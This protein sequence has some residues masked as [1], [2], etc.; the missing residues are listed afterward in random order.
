MSV[1]KIAINDYDYALPE[2]RIAKYPLPKRDESKLLIYKN[3]GI[4][5][6]IFRNLPE[7]IPPESQLYVNDT[8]V[9]HA[10]LKFK[11]LTGAKIELFCLTPFEPVDY[12]ISFSQTKTCTWICMVGNLKKWKNEILQLDFVSN[13]VKYSLKA[14]KVDLAGGHAIVRFKWDGDLSFGEVLDSL[15]K[16]PIPPYL[17][18]E[19][20]TIDDSRYQT[21][22]SDIKGSVAAPTAGLHITQDVISKLKKKNIVPQTIT[23]HVGAGT[24][25]PVK[26]DN[27]LKHAMHSEVFSVS[28]QTLT[29]LAE[30]NTPVIATGTTTLRTLESLY[31]LGVKSIEAQKLC[32]KLEQWDHK[33]LPDNL[34]SKEVFKKLVEILKQENIKNFNAE[35]AIMI[36]PSYNFKLVDGLITNFH[37]PSSTLLLLVAAFIGD[38]WKDVY[39]YAM[40]NNFRF[41]SYGDSSILWRR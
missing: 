16:I 26:T 29:N 9:I 30:S 39:D 35:T 25:Q 32:F 24:F 40:K 37:Q 8:R 18:R 17:N 21:I 28:M 41:L 4:D 10:R 6:S 13:S 20:E 27:A 11:K 38:N 19:S 31:W 2:E 12:Q 33:T 1:E 23:L 3:N 5:E 36:V 14:E 34:S 7:F 15:G 22:Y